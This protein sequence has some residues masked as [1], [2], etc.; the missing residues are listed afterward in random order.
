MNDNI[1]GPGRVHDGNR[2]KDL[3]ADGRPNVPRNSPT[4]FNIQFYDR[5]IF[6]DGR[7]EVLEDEIV[8]HGQGQSLRTPDSILNQPDP[9][10]GQNLS[11]AQALFP[12][13]SNNEM[14]GHG[15][16]S[17]LVND[18]K[19]LIIENRLQGDGLQSGD[20]P[21]NNWQSWFE[22]AF[23]D[24][25]DKEDLITIENVAEALSVYQR[26][27][28]FIKNPWNDYLDGNL[29]AISADAKAGA[30]LFFKT[31]GRR[32]LRM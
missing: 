23:G 10:A 13:V 14:F 3:L 17:I 25:E 32:R 21:V 19:R 22:N 1:L 16:S 4:I 26:S 28:V 29:D 20:L 31:I 30:A 27:Q 24:V 6:W 5:S 11:M 8:A 12:I 7:I 15:L 2:L 9:D 18:A